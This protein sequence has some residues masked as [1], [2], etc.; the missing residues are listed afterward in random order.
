[1]RNS[2]RM[3]LGILSIALVACLSAA[4]PHPQDAVKVA[5]NNFKVLLDNDHVRVLEFHG[6][7]GYKVG[8]HSHPN[9]VTYTI[10]GSGKTT[11]TSADGKTTES[12]NRSGVAAWHDAETHSSE[13]TGAVHAL[14]IE[15]KH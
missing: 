9:Y 14:L 6:K 10:S 11:F 3:I 12:E 8:M 15:M 2:R 4:S 1:M 13:S 5:P 7:A